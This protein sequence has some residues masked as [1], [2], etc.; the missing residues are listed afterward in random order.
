MKPVKTYFKHH[1]KI[2][3][4]LL[5]N[6][7]APHNPE[8]F[9]QLRIEIKKL[10]AFFKLL[11]FCSKDFPRKKT[12]R[13][14]KIIFKQAGIVRELDIAKTVVERSLPDSSLPQY[15]NYL[16]KITAKQC[17]LFFSLVH[18]HKVKSFK[19]THKKTAPFLSGITEKKS[20]RYLHKLYE[21][22][23]ERS[24][25]KNVASAKQQHNVRK[26]LKTISFTKKCLG[27][28]KE[29]QSNK[30]EYALSHL[31]GAWHDDYVTMRYL[32]KAMR[33][34]AIPPNEK[35]QLKIIAST[36]AEENKLLLKKINASKAKL[37]ASNEQPVF[38]SIYK[39]Q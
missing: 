13:P 16:E 24:G 32:H 9:H 31:L 1:L 30:P 11:K 18:K 28:E 23:Y 6:T 33:S 36:L 3:S 39:H 2:V 14:Y 20:N 4:A 21:L 7:S 22:M 35:H 17:A 19:T 12:L 29:E 25:K 34:A 10:A 27:L 37:H 8:S 5:Q 15:S 38:H 26:L